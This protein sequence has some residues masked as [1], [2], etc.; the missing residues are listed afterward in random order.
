MLLANNFLEQLKLLSDLDRNIKITLTSA[1]IDTEEIH[2]LV[3]K[4]EQLLLTIISDV[5]KSPELA[6]TEQ[7]QKAIALTKEVVDLM[8]QQTAAIG[9]T[10]HKYRH[11]SKS[12]QQYK[13]FL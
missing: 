8:A 6:E 9:Q 2:S 7:W 3:D 1:D 5:K 13:K 10:L 4:R 12:V 11:G